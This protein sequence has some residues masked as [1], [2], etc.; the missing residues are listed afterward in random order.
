MR[1]AGSC[2]LTGKHANVDISAMMTEPLRNRLWQAFDFETGL[3]KRC[4]KME[5]WPMEDRISRPFL[6]YLGRAALES[7]VP[8]KTTEGFLVMFDRCDCCL[9]STIAHQLG[10]V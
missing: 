5:S 6:Y 3:P 9:N 8:T 10:C 1:L 7:F 2:N 4:V